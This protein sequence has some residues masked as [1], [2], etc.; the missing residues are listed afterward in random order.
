MTSLREVQRRAYRAFLNGDASVVTPD[1]AGNNIPRTIQV[2]IYQNNAR[3]TFRK[4]LASSYTVVE[5]LVG[6]ACFRGLCREYLRRYPSCS[7]SLQHFGAN[8]FELLADQ[9]GG[10]QY[11]YLPDVA[12]LE[13]ACEEVLADRE[14]D[15]LDLQTLVDVSPADCASLQFRFLK[16]ISVIGSNYPVLAIWRAN[17]P[18]ESA[19][20]DLSGGSEHVAV[21]RRDG[22]AVLRLI[23]PDVYKLIQSLQTGMTLGEAC[24]SALSSTDQSE[25]IKALESLMTLGVSIGQC[26]SKS[27]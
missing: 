2:Q 19:T 17:Q 25:L 20:V 12:H 4:T 14:C 5:R 22:D 13:W 8:F 18:G 7:G 1:L 21:M 24:G 10:T 11:E 6:D 3:E 15:S 27:R 9:F 26:H 16:R 23:S